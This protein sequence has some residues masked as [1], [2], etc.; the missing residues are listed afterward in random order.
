MN[1]VKV[2]VFQ[3]FASFSI[4]YAS[5]FDVRDLPKM[6]FSVLISGLFN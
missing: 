5:Y 2:I 1:E 4:L 3:V 6:I